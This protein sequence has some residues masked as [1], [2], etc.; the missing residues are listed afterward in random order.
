M[1]SRRLYFLWVGGHN[2][3]ARKLALMF[4]AYGCVKRVWA[5]WE[6]VTLLGWRWGGQLSACIWWLVGVWIY[7]SIPLLGKLYFLKWPYIDFQDYVQI[8]FS[9]LDYRYG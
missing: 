6:M 5:E 9:F 3:W 7:S 1:K 8:I 2:E 4:K